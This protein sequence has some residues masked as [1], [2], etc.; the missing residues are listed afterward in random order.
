M[1]E[2]NDIPF[3]KMQGTGNDFVVIDNRGSDYS[4]EQLIALT[5]QICHRKYGVGADGLLALQ[6]PVMDET[7][8]E[9]L[10]RNADGSDAGM[11]GNGS[12]CLALF[13]SSLGM[14]EALHFSVH[15]RIY[16]ATVRND[17]QVEIRFP[18]STK[19][20]EVTIDGDHLL[21]MFTG[22]EHV[23]M[24]V[25][26]LKL[27][28]EEYLVAMGRKLRYHDFFKPKGT[29]ANF[30]CGINEQK[31]TVQTYER[32]V[33]N[34]TLACGTGAI[35]SAIAWHHQQQLEVRDNEITVQTKGGELLVDFTY[36]PEIEAYT[37]IRL[38]GPAH[39]VFRGM[40][41]VE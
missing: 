31:I 26:R 10:Y 38:T 18:V 21:Q 39:F 35:A 33:E 15:D 37:D 4:L 2:N 28:E 22:T 6:E 41:Y 30:F 19:V 27:E 14:G 40:Y 8:Y 3:I 23:A 13:A 9:M 20:R 17:Q 7:D 32:G 1:A 25:P 36:K 16:A 24:Q 34:L 11:C 12:R 5:P 29:N